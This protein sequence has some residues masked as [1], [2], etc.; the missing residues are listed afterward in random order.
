[1]K[2]VVVVYGT[3]EGQTAKVAQHL[4]HLGCSF[5][6]EVDAVHA[7]DPPDGFSLER[8]DA[9]LVGG[10]LHEGR[11]QRYLWRWARDHA[12]WL[13]DHPTGLFCVC[14]TAAGH[15]AEAH[16]EVEAI[17]DRFQKETGWVPGQRTLVAGAL[18]Y[19]QYSWLK[20][21]LMKK[22]AAEAGGD[23]DTS[24]DHEYTDWDALDAWARPFFQQL[25]A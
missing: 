12:A 7:A 11:F 19:S 16:A 20:R 25:S 21:Y 15:D 5:D 2:R 3:T 9:A 1:M 22:I 24:R 8:Y 18:R 4:V 10:S 17:L 6:L 13:G 14:L 23:T